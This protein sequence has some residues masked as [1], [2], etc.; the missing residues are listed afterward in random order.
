MAQRRSSRKA[1]EEAIKNNAK[2]EAIEK[3]KEEAIEKA[4]EK[5]KIR[6]AKRKKKAK[7]AKEE[8]IEKLDSSS[9]VNPGTKKR[10]TSTPEPSGRP[11]KALK[12]AH[13]ET[14]LTHVDKGA[15][16]VDTQ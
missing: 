11:Q 7:E 16:D 3:A 10:T 12:K 2:E 5:A 14:A 1:N 15:E 4:K 6:R 13:K 9:I 8:A